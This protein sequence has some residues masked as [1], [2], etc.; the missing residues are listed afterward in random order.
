MEYI[1]LASGIHQTAIA[2]TYCI[3]LYRYQSDVTVLPNCTHILKR[4]NTTY[5]LHKKS[6]ATQPNLSDFYLLHL[7]FEI[8]A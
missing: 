7:L 2:I 1:F 4:C 6:I 8:G 5:I 3:R